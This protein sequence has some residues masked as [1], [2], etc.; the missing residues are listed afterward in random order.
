MTAATRRAKHT[1]VRIDV[2]VSTDSLDGDRSASAVVGAGISECTP[3]SG[4]RHRHK[5]VTVPGTWERRG[6]W[7]GHMPG[8][9][10]S[11]HQPTASPSLRKSE[12]ARYTPFTGGSPFVTH[13]G[14]GLRPGWRPK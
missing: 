8:P 11:A 2:T 9:T 3:K 14:G 6:W 1:S 7:A 5:L 12:A 4:A 13:S 10:G